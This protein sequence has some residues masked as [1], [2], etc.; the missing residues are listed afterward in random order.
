V[1]FLLNYTRNLL[2]V[3]LGRQP[4]RPLLFSYYVTHRCELNCAYCSDGDGKRFKEERVEE[5]ATEDARRLLRILRRET[6][7]LD[8]TGGEPLQRADLEDLLAEAHALGFRTI[9]NTKGIALR[10]RPALLRGLDTLVLSVDALEPHRLAPL[11]GRP[12]E[13]AERV[14]ET[15]RFLTEPRKEKRPRVVLSSVAAPENLGDVAA[16]LRFALEHRFAFHISPQ[17]M[18]I[19]AR[20]ELRTD[21]RYREL[22]EQVRCAKRA[23]RGVLGL[24][25]YLQ[26][27]RD[28]RAFRCHP[29]LMPI[30]RPDGRLYYPCLESKQ[31]DISVLEAGSYPTALRAA[32]ERHGALPKCGDCCH[33]FCHMA[34]SLLQ[35]HPLAA[36]AEGRHYGGT[37]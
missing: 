29:L 15:L 11:I 35:R 13:T 4:Q 17:I 34:L 7:T 20:P 28:F 3:A 6:D 2:A 14:L 10:E 32:R 24:D 36:L 31:A 21:P 30:I 25:A 33:I 12:T 18:G 19:H 16:V 1:G 8:I 9:L 22:I 37:G 26:G 5:L 27:I 23:Q